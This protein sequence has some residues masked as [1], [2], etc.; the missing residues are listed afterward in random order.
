MIPNDEKIAETGSQYRMPDG[1]VID[2]NN[3]TG[4]WE[5]RKPCWSEQEQQILFR[6]TRGRFYARKRYL[7]FKWLSNEEAAAWLLVNGYNP[8]DN[9]WPEELTAIADVIRD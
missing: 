7:R 9:D 3:A 5:G 8:V 1:I 4:H 6:S 2:T